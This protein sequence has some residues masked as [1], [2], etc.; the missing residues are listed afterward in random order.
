VDAKPLYWVG[1]AREDLRDLPE[2]VRRELGF[3]LR[4]VQLGEMSRDWKTMASVGAGVV[5]IRVRV[6]GAYRLMYVAKFVEAI[7]VLH[8]F[9]KKTQQTAAMDL[10][11]ARARLNAV[12]RARTEG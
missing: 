7:Y 9:Q 2:N 11:V 10:E 1:S 8:V 3:D 12:R 4:R 5:E 6:G